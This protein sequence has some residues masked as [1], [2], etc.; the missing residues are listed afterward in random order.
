MERITTR[1]RILGIFWLFAGSNHFAM[2]RF[3]EAIMPAYLPAHRELVVISG[4]AE[5]LGGAM[6]LT[7]GLKRPARWWLLATL[8]A[9]FPANIWVA[10]NP[11]D[12]K[13]LDLDR[14]P[15]W[16]LWARLPF[17]AVFA[18]WVWWATE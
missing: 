18:A 12:I 8:L 16:T 9:I 1:Q 10:T 7:P 5:W 17:Q 6:V 13:G 4:V 3:Y 15:R 2:M 14:I 11:K